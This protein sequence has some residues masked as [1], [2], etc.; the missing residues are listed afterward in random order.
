MIQYNFFQKLIG[1]TTCNIVGNAVLGDIR[2]L[3]Y[4]LPLV[5]TKNG[6]VLSSGLDIYNLHLIYD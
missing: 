3:Q 2:F 6:V 5:N 4:S 1:V